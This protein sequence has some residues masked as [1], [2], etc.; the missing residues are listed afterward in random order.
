MVDAGERRCPRPQLL[1]S[2]PPSIPNPRG[3][4]EPA[5]KVRR[6]GSGAMAEP[7][8]GSTPDGFAARY[9]RPA[10]PYDPR[11]TCATV[12]LSK[13]VNPKFVQELPGHADTKLTL[14]TCSPSLPG[15][16]AQTATAMG[17]AL[18]QNGCSTVAVKGPR[19]HTRGPILAPRSSSRETKE[20]ERA[21]ERTRSADLLSLRVSC[22]KAKKAPR[23]ASPR[24]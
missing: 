7:R 9:H 22:S 6:T 1:V 12:L 5:P 11:G 17:S 20:K 21:D 4:A 2:A 19:R 16:G 14:G 10:W 13:G 23:A 18:G 15:L 24:Y 8:P 3:K